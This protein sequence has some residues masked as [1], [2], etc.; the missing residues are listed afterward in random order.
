MYMWVEIDASGG[1][2]FEM[3]RTGGVLF[4]T[5]VAVAG[6]ERVGGM[7]YWVEVV[8]RGVS[9]IPTIPLSTDMD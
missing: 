6:D 3:F 4:E 5:L 2:V 8:V 1:T 7:H 9:L